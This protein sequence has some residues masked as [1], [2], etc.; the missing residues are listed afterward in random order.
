M[1]SVIMTSPGNST[2][3][4]SR[5][6]NAATSLLARSSKNR[7]TNNKNHAINHKNNRNINSRSNS[8]RNNTNLRQVNNYNRN[9]N[10]NHENSNCI[11]NN[12]NLPP[13]KNIQNN[14]FYHGAFA[15]YVFR[16]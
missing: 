2:R 15:R 11:N 6:R 1:D 7:Q 12:G 5:L 10:G 13:T 14:T 8:L 3:L 9:I 4:K 16:S